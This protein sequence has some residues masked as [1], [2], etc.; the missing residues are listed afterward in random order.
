MSP[1]KH[2]TCRSSSKIL[3]DIGLSISHHHNVP[4]SLCFLVY[5]KKE[6]PQRKAKAGNNTVGQ[7]VEGVSWPRWDRKS[8]RHQFH[9]A[10]IEIWVSFWSSSTPYRR[11]HF[12]WKVESKT[13]VGGAGLVW[14]VAGRRRSVRKR[15]A[16]VRPQAKVEW[17]SGTLPSCLLTTASSW[18]WG[19]LFW[20]Q[21][22][23][24]SYV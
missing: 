21:Q 12:L 13:G 6:K 5:F 9:D 11:N 23:R 24:L 1:A 18:V 15:T 3:L 8:T 19:Q 20:V 14:H 22:E 10:T 4:P 7:D 16:D 17:G 2:W